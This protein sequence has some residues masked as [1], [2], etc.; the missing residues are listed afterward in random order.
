MRALLSSGRSKDSHPDHKHLADHMD[1]YATNEPFKTFFGSER[2]T[3]FA[4]K[5]RDANR[6]VIKA[7]AATPTPASSIFGLSALSLTA[8]RTDDVSTEVKIAREK[9]ACYTESFSLWAVSKLDWQEHYDNLSTELQ[10]KPPT[11]KEQV[12]A[13]RKMLDEWEDKHLEELTDM[14]EKRKKD[15]EKKVDE[16]KGQTRGIG[17]LG[18]EMVRKHWRLGAALD[19]L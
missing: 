2:E 6:E 10:R 17:G 14:L 13:V 7:N 4:Q 16:F 5:I 1:S 9:V 19:G 3:T 15:M 12:L 8:S 11:T 18:A